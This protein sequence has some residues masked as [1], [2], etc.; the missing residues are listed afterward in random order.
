M[1]PPMFL[2]ACEASGIVR[3]AFRANGHEAWSCDLLPSDSPF[4]IQDDVRRVIRMEEWSGMIA[5]PPCT[6]LTNAGVRWLNDPPGKLEASHYPEEI[7]VAY[8]TWSREERLAF[9]WDELEKGAAL[10]SDLWNADIP[11][12]CLENPIMHKHAKARIENFENF[13]QSIQPWQFGRN[14]AGPDNVKKRVCLWLSGF[15]P[16]RKTGTLDG[17]TAR[18]EVHFARSSADRWKER[19]VFFPGIAKAMAAQWGGLD[20]PDQLNLAI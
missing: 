17:K 12:K 1:K 2:I 13:S 15:P 18:P 10:F 20:F 3:D 5:H 8:L 19:S 9:M 7:R 11:R 6:R 4:H 16:L 14:Q